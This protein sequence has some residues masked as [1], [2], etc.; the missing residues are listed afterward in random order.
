[1]PLPVLDSCYRSKILLYL[2]RRYCLA[3]KKITDSVRAVHCNV[4]Y[5]YE[6][7]P[8]AISLYTVSYCKLHLQQEVNSIILSICT[9]MSIYI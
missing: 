8:T 1:M 3:I 7:A 2:K 9:I 5:F 4:L 6:T